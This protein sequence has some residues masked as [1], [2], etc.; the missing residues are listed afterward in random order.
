[1]NVFDAKK[2]ITVFLMLATA[3]SSLGLVFLNFG[4]QNSESPVTATQP[5]TDNGSVPQNAFAPPQ[6]S[7]GVSPLFLAY[8]NN[9]TQNATNTNSNITDAVLSEIGKSIVDANPDGPVASANGAFSIHS[10]DL[11][12]IA[13]IIGQ[14]GAIQDFTLP[15]WDTEASFTI[16]VIENPS[17]G[18]LVAYNNRLGETLSSVAGSD[19]AN[20]F[21]TQTAVDPSKIPDVEKRAAASLNELKSLS[22]PKPFVALHTSIVRLVAYEDNILK[23][24][25][26]FT[27]DPI[28]AAL[29]I[30]G[31]SARYTAAVDNVQTQLDQTRAA[32]GSLYPGRSERGIIGAI[33]EFFVPH[34]AY[35]FGAG[36]PVFD[37][38][39]LIQNT[40]Q[41]AKTI[42]EQLQEMLISFL[43]NTVLNELT[44]E[45]I[46]W[47]Q[48]GGKPM[49]ITNWQTF[50]D[51]TVKT[52]AQL[53]IGVVAA[54][55]CRRFGP[56]IQKQLRAIYNVPGM[57][58]QGS[59]YL[60]Q[61]VGDTA[62]FFNDFGYGG[63]TAYAASVLPSG[64]YYGSYYEASQI[65][66]NAAQQAQTTQQTEAQTNKGFLPSKICTNKQQVTGV[67]D[68]T[69]PTPP[70]QSAAPGGS[71][72][73]FNPNDPFGTSGTGST[74]S[75]AGQPSSQNSLTP[76][77]TLK[78]NGNY[79]GSKCNKSTGLCNVTMC[80]S[81]NDWQS[82][83]PGVAIAD[84]L[85]IALGSPTNRIASA[86]KGDLMAIVAALIDSALNKL[87][88]AGENGI[89]GLF[90]GGGNNNTG[91][92]GPGSMGSPAGSDNTGVTQAA[93]QY[94]A[95]LQSVI[96]NDNQWFALEPQAVNL[97]GQVA[98]S[99]ASTT[100]S[101]QT[102]IDTLNS[103]VPAVQDEVATTTALMTQLAAIEDQVKNATDAAQQATLLSQ[104]V[105]VFESDAITAM[106]SA[107]GER[108]NALLTL[109]QELQAALASPPATC[110]A[111][112]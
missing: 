107:S 16:R 82:T 92:G 67:K 94:R 91:A 23:L 25:N 75:S 4:G 1:M 8:E 49:F 79:V 32:I 98:S 66:G 50:L 101:A 95:Q 87:V 42:W 19:I 2:L 9:A 53:S 44:H 97:L 68:S 88:M 29:I 13:S 31:Y 36:V 102:Q 69:T 83:T 71:S 6:T 78:Q 14:T 109:Q 105:A 73:G 84:Q 58:V 90:S 27:A 34:R 81:S 3:V 111:S 33:E 61:L 62:L 52:A 63:W 20:L 77:S 70:N 60:D 26:N 37:T 64:N 59:C 40:G 30:Q 56:N 55:I 108:Y 18:D 12:N 72:T 39:N 45:I 43:T 93:N 74:L 100:E 24:A 35:A 11:Q 65:V 46:T 5:A 28:K 41:L 99:C 85:S 112:L 10:P 47:I 54:N 106:I 76:L 89:L 48:G 51:D 103:L 7:G 110:P 57:P 21:Q 80:A 38:P 17:R 96:D 86:A 104:M 15:S 22:V